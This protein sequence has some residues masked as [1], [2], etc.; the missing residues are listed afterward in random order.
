MAERDR[1]WPPPL[2]GDL[3]RNFANFTLTLYSD[4][5]IS[6][7]MA[8]QRIEWPATMPREISSRFAKLRA[9]R[10]LLRAGGRMPPV[11]AKGNSAFAGTCSASG[12]IRYPRRVRPRSTGLVPKAGQCI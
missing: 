9:S 7:A 12:A 11:S 8:L 1:P 3:P 2:L 6:S 10:E 5:E 4:P